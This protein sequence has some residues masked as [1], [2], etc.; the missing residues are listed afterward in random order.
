MSNIIAVKLPNSYKAKLAARDKDLKELGVAIA[1]TKNLALQYK[2]AFIEL[3]A[4]AELCQSTGESLFTSLALDSLVKASPISDGSPLQD[5]DLI[6]HKIYT[7]L[8]AAA[9]M[10]TE[11]KKITAGQELVSTTMRSASGSMTPT[12]KAKHAPRQ[13]TSHISAIERHLGDNDDED[14]EN[15]GP[16]PQHQAREGDRTLATFPKPPLPQG[17]RRMQ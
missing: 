15:A 16:P 7:L 13:M 4:L 9:L 1:G 14:D 8:A 2:D 11:Y 3:K 6:C 10:Q 12:E 5:K 17:V